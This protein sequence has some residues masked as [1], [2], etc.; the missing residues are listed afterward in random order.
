MIQIEASFINMH[1]VIKPI[2]YFIHSP[3]KI[4]SLSGPGCNE[5]NTFGHSSVLRHVILQITEMCW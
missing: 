3:L 1:N 2:L 4:T 5:N